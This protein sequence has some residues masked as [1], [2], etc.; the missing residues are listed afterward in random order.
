MEFDTTL[1]DLDRL[2]KIYNIVDDIDLRI[3]TKSNTLS[4]P[5]IGYVTLY[6][7]CFKLIFFCFMNFFLH[8]FPTWHRTIE[9]NCWILFHLEEVLKL[10]IFSSRPP[11]RRILIEQTW[12]NFDFCLTSRMLWDF[13][14]FICLRNIQNQL[15]AWLNLNEQASANFDCYLASSI[16][17]DLKSFI[18]LSIFFC[19]CPPA[20]LCLI[21]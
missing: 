14:T 10:R 12:A 6:L 1:E 20:W 5:P 17:R 8:K 16:L 9:Y 7:K 21:E 11:S 2:R 18:C 19:N 3:L 13:K 4:H 15:L